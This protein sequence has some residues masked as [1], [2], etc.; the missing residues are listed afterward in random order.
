MIVYFNFNVGS[1]IEYAGDI[2]KT[3]LKFAYASAVQDLTA[4]I[5][6]VKEQ[7]HE[8]ML[9]DILAENKPKM[10][11]LNEI[12]DRSIIP[13]FY[14]KKL[15]PDT[16]IV[17]MAHVW[18]QIRSI[19][20]DPSYSNITTN[21]F[22]DMCNIVYTLNCNPGYNFVLKNTKMLNFYYPTDNTFKSTVDWI[23]REGLFCYV[24]NILPHKISPDFI[25]LIKGTKIIID[26][27]G[28]KFDNAEYNALFDTA[29]N[30]VYKGT[31]PQEMVPDV[32][33]KYKYFVLPHDG[34]EP[35]N[36]TILQSAFCGTIPLVTNDRSSTTYDGTWM[37][38][39]KGLCNVCVKPDELVNNLIQYIEAPV[40][41]SE[42]SDTIRMISNR[43]FNYTNFRNNFIETIS[44]LYKA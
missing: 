39:A 23:N 36:W 1:A 16:K 35:F 19:V 32:L 30:F 25:N 11:V 22:F 15:Y 17:L 18:Q 42:Y 12:F 9:I 5:I 43:K 10:I 14:Y 13:S 44:E 37:D 3:W 38:W 2:F 27:Y 33:N 41:E 21:K 4:E 8:A 6:E 7:T 29:D 26:C 28:N 40:D 31:V 20:A 34:F 24:G